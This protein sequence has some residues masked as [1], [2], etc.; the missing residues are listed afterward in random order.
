MAVFDTSVLISA[1]A[2][3]AW[4][5]GALEKYS[6]S[7]FATTSINVYELLKGSEGRTEKEN[8]V[9]REL[10]GNL[11]VRDLDDLSVYKAA[12][13]F[14]E[15]KEKGKMI[16]GFDILIAA[17]AIAG[18]ETLVVSDKHFDLIDYGGIVSIGRNLRL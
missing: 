18:N 7:G 10:L 15:L 1:L 11:S 8:R 4:A 2:G 14:G 17:I 9:I 12:Q 16:E 3:E 5:V 13:L 6:S